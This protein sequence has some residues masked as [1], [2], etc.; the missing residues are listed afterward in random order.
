VRGN[1]YVVGDVTYADA[2]GQ[3]GV[4]ADGTSNALALTAGGSIMLGDYLTIRGK[5]HSQ[6]ASEY[7]NFAGA[8]DMRAEHRNQNLTKSGTTETVAIGYFD[9]GVVDAGVAQGN[10]P[11]GSFTTSELMLFNRM[12]HQKATADPT[13]RPRYYRLRPTM[14]I[15]EYVGTGEHTVKYNNP[16]VSTITDLSNATIHDLNPRD[17]WLTEDQ[18]RRFWYADEMTRPSSGRPFQIDGLLYSNNSI[19]CIARSNMRTATTGHRSYAF[20]QMTIRGGVVAAD[21]GMFIPGSETQGV[22]RKGLDMY[23]DPRVDNFLRVEDPT[24]VQ[25]AR[26]AYRHE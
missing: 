19:F 3:F 7:P 8:I 18:L 14:P 20:G 16:A 21:L 6:D 4:A 10:Q 26:L 12:E 17:Y 13:Y 24:Q 2:P 11:Q 9:P 15:Y 25:F 22:N 23:Y 5:N 1:A